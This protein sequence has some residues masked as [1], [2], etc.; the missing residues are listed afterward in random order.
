MNDVVEWKL[1]TIEEDQHKV[2]EYYTDRFLTWSKILKDKK[3]QQKHSE[4]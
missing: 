3:F 4:L 1:K 2:A